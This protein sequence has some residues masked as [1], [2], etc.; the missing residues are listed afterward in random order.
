M[1]VLNRR[2]VECAILVGL[3]LNCDITH[4]NKFDRKNYF[5]PDLPKAYQISQLYFPICRDGYLEID[6]SDGVKR[7]GIHEIHMEE[8]AG[9]L[10]HDPW[11]DRTFVDF[12]RCGVPLLEIVTEPD[13]RSAEEVTAYLEKLREILLF[14]GVSDC[15]MQEGSMRADINI[16]V[17]PIGSS[18]LG[19][20]TEMKNMNS[21][22]AISRAVEYETR[23]QIEV[24]EAGGAIVQQTRR[25]DDNKDASFAMR[26]KENAQD[27]R[28][29]PEPDLLPL[30]IDDE[31][32][33]AARE[34]MPELAEEK[35]RRYM[36]DF[37]LSEYD[38]RVLT[39]FREWA[40]LFEN[41]AE[42]SG[43]PKEA[44]NMIMVDI[45]RLC[46]ENSILP[47]NLKISPDKISALIELITTQKIN[48]TVGK[49]ALEEIFYRDVD[50]VKYVEENEL[51]AIGDRDELLAAVKTTLNECPKSVEDFK[52]GKQKAFGFLVGQIMRAFGGKADPKSVNALLKE[53]LEK[54]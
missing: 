19:T 20:R 54:I 43:Q 24:I 32:I 3:A 26:S 49:T 33:S 40:L 6:S 4:R 50:P 7:I 36:N 44:A 11:D 38:A 31:W 27:Y 39:S 46:S 5:Y 22:K 2:A 23:R 14:L 47:E 42:L 18:E 51:L 15:K 16:S 12:N 30:H 53:E 34:A 1:P 13:F 29:F 28:Y 45:A 52:N 25:W 41:I 8:D 9:K 17:R 37:G 48:R 21:F 10:I 35:R